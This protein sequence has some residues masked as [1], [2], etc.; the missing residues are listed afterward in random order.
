MTCA[1][2]PKFQAVIEK[3]LADSRIQKA[4]AFL[5]ADQENKIVE[6]K[7]MVLLHGAPFKERELRSPMFKE[8]LAKYGAVDCFV[9]SHDNAFGYVRGGDGPV[10]VVEAH[11]DTV[12]DASTPLNVTEKD[13][14]ISCPG[15]G[16]DTAGLANVLS[17]LR[18]ITHAGLVPSGTF[19]VGGTVGEEGEGDIRGIKGLLDDHK[20]INAVV[21]VEP[22]AGGHVTYGAIGSRR[23]EFVFKGPGGHSWFAYGL[24]S[25]IHAMGRAIGAM[26]EVAPG[27]SPKT[28]YTVGIVEGGTSVNSIANEARMKLDMRSLSPESLAA[29]EKTMLGIVDGAVKAENSFRADSGQ[30]ITVEKILIGDRPAGVQPE[31]A[32][33]VQA[34]CAAIAGVGGEPNLTPHS[35]TNANAPISR[36]IPAVVLRT[37]GATGGT[38]AL[39][40]WFEPEG[41]QMGAKATLLLLFALAGLPGVVEPVAL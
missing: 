31:T 2:D 9:D 15:I 16:D 38:H 39:D 36:G 28:T 22:G 7:E 20:N 14:R 8:K 18:A 1:V 3:L 41:S 26:A 29:L 30:K 6:L 17:C 24:P 5:D 27:A 13:G 40:E 35:S 10:V 19:L 11:L 37:G 4:L 21:S 12:F 25:P 33:V 23:Y 34:A 32:A